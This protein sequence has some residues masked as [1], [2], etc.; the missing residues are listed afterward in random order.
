MSAKWYSEDPRTKEWTSYDAA[1]TA[2]LEKSWK[3][4]KANVQLDFCGTSFTVDLKK[5]VQTNSSGGSRKVRRDAIAE[6]SAAVKKFVAGMTEDGVLDTSKLGHFFGALE[7]DA[8]TAAPFILFYHFGVAGCWEA[9][10]DELLT[11]FAMHNL[12]PTPKAVNA[13]LAKW[14]TELA[15]NFAEFT[16]FFD[17]VFKFCRPTPS[18]KAIA[19]EDL[20]EPM[21][22]ALSV[23]PK[24]TFGPP[25]RLV[26]YYASKVKGV[27]YDLWKQTV[28][29]LH[30]IKP[31]CSNYSED[32]CW[33]T[34]LD[35]YAEKIKS[36]KA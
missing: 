2:A 17:F 18:A 3:G 19:F 33:N 15:T 31:D 21:L 16:K 32:D 30:E 11:G 12:E 34:V 29:F 10:A 27:S 4:T 1:D 23:H 6:P 20:K 5:M 7:V 36:S 24:Y 25:S 8:S 22:V 13:R 35:D 9:T 14:Q 28:R 26:D